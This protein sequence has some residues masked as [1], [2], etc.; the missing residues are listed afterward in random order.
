MQDKVNKF[1]ISKSTNCPTITQ[2]DEKIKNKTE[3][4][5]RAVGRTENKKDGG[6]INEI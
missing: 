1:D 6:L 2:G 5:K 4:N 3:V